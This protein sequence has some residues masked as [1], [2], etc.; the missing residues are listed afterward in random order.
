MTVTLS[1]YR[2]QKARYLFNLFSAL[3]AVSWQFLTGNIVT[4]LALRLGAGPTYIGV[5]SATLYVAFF[6]LPL[7]KL[8]AAR[9]P[10]VTIFTGAWAARSVS[11]IPLLFIPFVYAS[12]QRETA[13]FLL[14]LGVSLFHIIRG[15]GMIGNNPILG[16]LSAGPDRGSYMTLVQIITSAVGMFAGF[17]IALLLG[18][19]PPLFLYAIIIGIGIVT[20]V[21]SSLVMRKVP[22]PENVDGE[23]SKKI[24]EVFRESMAE[25]PLRRFIFILLMVA[26]VS[27]VSRIFLVVYSREVFNQSDGMIALFAVFGGLGSL[28][29]KLLIRFLVDQ[30]GAKPIFLVCVFVG[31]VSM[32]PILFFPALES[33]N[34]TTI[35]LYLSFLFFMIFFGWLGAEGIMQTYFLGLVPEEKIMDMGVIFFFGYGIAGAGGSLLS[36]LLIDATTAIFG[37]ALVSFRLFYAL[38]IVISA[39][40]LVFMRKLIP[41]GALPFKD[42]LEVMFSYRDLRAISLMGKLNKTSDLSEEKA[43]LGA[44]HAA[45]SSMAIKSLIARAKSPRLSVRMESIRAIDALPVLSEAAEQALI[46]DVINNPYTTAYRSAQ[47][48]GN[49]RVFRAIVLLREL[50]VSGDYMLAGEAMIALAKLRDI[51]FRPH[52]EQVIKEAENPR[53]ILA[54]VEAIGIYGKADSLPVL[55]DMFRRVAP[56]PSF[57]DETVLAIAGILGVQSKFYPLLVRFLTDESMIA[58]LSMD[59][60]EAALEYCASVLGR[61]QGKNSASDLDNQARALQA[62]LVEFVK[63]SD[64]SLLSRW[65]L[66]LPDN[67]V[68]ELSRKTL[69]EAVLDKELTIHPRLRLLITHWCAH[70]LRRWVGRQA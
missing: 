8:F 6:F 32:V 58:A 37:S 2:L 18:R 17:I 21:S 36:G 35:T 50:A 27:G 28:I 5:V 53:L 43:I 44:L 20:G 29:A 66:G 1:P 30:I 70:E 15:V 45:P 54:G 40:A 68:Q 64:G 51:A 42:A 69:S 13:L 63:N 11:M 19:D 31:L 25:P 59:E 65:I 14:L 41:L 62:A 23:K 7:G 34:F 57:Q 47:A 52:I 48:L 12:G 39:A 22:G 9:Y 16:F 56:S 3:N 4:L 10:V 49:H 26:F 38:L 55:L 24:I 60:A 61:K 33:Y 67:L 46:D